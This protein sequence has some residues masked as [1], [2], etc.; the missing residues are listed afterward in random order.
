M[1][2]GHLEE[3]SGREVVQGHLEP[4]GEGAAFERVGVCWQ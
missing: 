1:P 3:A 4:P 2:E